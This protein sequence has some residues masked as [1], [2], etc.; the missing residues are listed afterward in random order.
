M[1]ERLSKAEYFSA[2]APTEIPQ[3]FAERFEYDETKLTPRERK[4]SHRAS[5]ER[6]QEHH[7]RNAEIDKQNKIEK[8]RQLYFGWRVFFGINLAESHQENGH[9]VK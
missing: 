8:E 9:N 4:L 6:W 2:H 5:T 3:W 7:N 1:I